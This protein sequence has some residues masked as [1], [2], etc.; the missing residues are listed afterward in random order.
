MA[1]QVHVTSIEA[2]D[3]FRARLILFIAKARRSLDEVGDDVR[4]TRGW[5]EHDRRVHWGREVARRT[6]ALAQA[7]A[8]LMSARLSDLQDAIQVQQAAV[9]KA[10]RAVSEAEAKVETVKAW[11][12]NF[13]SR[14]DPLSKRLEGLRTVLD[15]DMPKALSYLI[16]ARNALEEYA[17]M[18]AAATA[19]AV[20]PPDAPPQ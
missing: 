11:N 6:K 1:D 15:Q 10:R 16:G 3:L 20:P 13:E 17:E 7:Q 12:R 9:L 18:P 5:L 19:A 14:A 8:D 2:L 4:R